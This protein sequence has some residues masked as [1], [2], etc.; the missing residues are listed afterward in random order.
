MGFQWSV[1]NVDNNNCTDILVGGEVSLSKS[2]SECKKIDLEF[3]ELCI[4]PAPIIILDPNDNQWQI[5]LAVG[6]FFAFQIA[7]CCCCYRRGCCGAAL[8]WRR[9]DNQPY[10][11][12]GFPIPPLPDDDEDDITL[13]GLSK[14]QNERLISND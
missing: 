13:E 5:G 1:R 12:V 4:D 7:T 10:D 11:A 9:R 2:M 8:C 3:L 14:L 6:A